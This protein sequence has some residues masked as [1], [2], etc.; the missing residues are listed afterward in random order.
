MEIDNNIK[1]VESN[2][3]VLISKILIYAALIKIIS[4]Y[5]GRETI[6]FPDYDYILREH[7]A[8]FFYR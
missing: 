2:N 8:A 6:V 7:K 3:R 4:E 5:T 1:N